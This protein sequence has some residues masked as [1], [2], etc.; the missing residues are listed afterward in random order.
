MVQ[1]DLSFNNRGVSREF[2]IIYRTKKKEHQ[3]MIVKP[4]MKGIVDS[5]ALLDTF[6]LDDSS[7]YLRQ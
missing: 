1:L 3:L 5:I 2:I 4:P 6:A 7:L